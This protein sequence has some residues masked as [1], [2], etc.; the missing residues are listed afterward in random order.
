MARAHEIAEVV[1]YLALD[2]PDHV[3]GADIIVDGGLTT[4]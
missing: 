4:W 3:N 2:S 1:T